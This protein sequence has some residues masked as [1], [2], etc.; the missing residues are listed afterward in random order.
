MRLILLT[1][2]AMLPLAANS[3][4]NRMAMVRGGIDP[5]SFGM[6]R[7]SAG[8]VAL[9]LLVAVLRGGLHWRML[10]IN[11]GV[12]WIGVGAL[13][14]YIFGF[15]LAHQELDAGLGALILFGVVQMT[16]FVGG[17]V[18]REAMPLLRWIGAG[19]AF[20]GLVWLLW[21]GAGLQISIVHGLLMALAGVGW[22][23]YSLAGRAGGDAIIGTAANFL[24]AAL[25][26]LGAGLLLP[27]G[28]PLRV[29]DGGGVALAVLS[30]AVT[31]GMGYALWYSVLPNLAAS[32]AA[33]VQLSVPVLATILSVIVLGEVVTADFVLAAG[34]VLGGVA[35]SL[36]PG[37]SRR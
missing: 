27:F 28:P 21:P 20:G 31:S 30:G 4:L 25:V 2:F 15:S 22:G 23:L 36:L 19:V 35:L 9:V 10:G 18:Q 13:L 12:R 29:T 26:A 1:A 3:V 5:V 17:L 7:L 24:L 37:L 32:V 34:L 14:V 8:A 11:R 33:V 6:I 16:M